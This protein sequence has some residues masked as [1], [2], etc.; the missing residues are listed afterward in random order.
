VGKVLIA[1]IDYGMGNNGSILNML[2]KLGA[3]AV[4]TSN[5]EDIKLASS[6]VLPGVGSFDSGMRHLDQS[7]LKEELRYKVLEEKTPIL[8]ICLGMQLMTRGS[9]EGVLAGLG[10]VDAEVKKFNFKRNEN[11]KVPHMGWNFVKILRSD[12][13]FCE[14]YSES[15]FY[16][17][18]S[19]YVSCHNQDVILATTDYGFDFTSAFQ[20]GNIMGVQFHP[21]KS[22]KFGKKV[23]ENFIGMSKC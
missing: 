14:I 2:K 16:F 15:R 4:V 19:Y 8:G 6:L 21:E 13:L 10:F 22:H 12:S 11:L 3:E 7:L 1:I 9:E 5:A 17:V 18:H 20:C 23:L